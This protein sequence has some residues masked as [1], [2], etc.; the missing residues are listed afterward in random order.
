MAIDKSLT[1]YGEEDGGMTVDLGEQD[2]SNIQV[3]MPGEQMPEPGEDGRPESIHKDN[4]VEY[5]EEEELVKIS[6]DVLEFYE[7]DKS[8]RDD[9]LRTYK[10]GLEYLG[11]SMEDRD[12]PFK[13]AS[14]VF[15]PLMAEA[16]VRFQSNAI[17]EIFPAAGPVL[18]SVVGDETPDKIQQARRVKEEFNYQLTENMSEY[19]GEME[20]MLFRL[21]LAGSVFKKVY[22]DPLKKRPS[23]CMVPAEDFIVNYG[24]SDLETAE[25]YFHEMKRSPNYVKKLMRSGFYRKVDLPLPTPEY[26]EGRTKE[27]KV[28][29]IRPSMEHDNRHTLIEAHMY[30]NL[31]G[32]FEDKNDIA[33][34]Y[35]ITVDKSSQK[36][37]A[38]YRNWDEAD[39]ERNCE[40]YFVHYQ[41]MPGLGF[42]G[43]GLAHLLGST[44]KAATSILR[45]LIDAGTFATLPG[46]LKTRGLKVKGDDTPIAPGEWRDVDVPGGKVGHH[47]P[48]PSLKKMITL[49]KKPVLFG[50]LWLI[51]PNVSA[52]AHAWPSPLA[53][54]RWTT[55]TLPTLWTPTLPTTTPF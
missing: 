16:V 25:R 42:Y 8:S 45:Q 36:I 40:Q 4:L 5:L 15:H 39:D 11:F 26:N 29:G 19:R 28:M 20:Q 49:L 31:P 55:K 14:G 12:R 54:S 10:Q 17:Q 44:A 9:W 53:S 48:F 2:Q 50:I 23:A 24:A 41:Y 32:A 1:P 34:P 43:F 37:L 18:T 22:Y 47:F 38:I 7:A 33:D 3:L 30:I 6:R 13:G 35:V 51:A 46:G 52:R 27:D 21:P